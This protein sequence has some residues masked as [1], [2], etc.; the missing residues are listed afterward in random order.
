MFSGSIDSQTY[1]SRA[2]P[3]L[4]RFF[5]FPLVS[6]SL[7][8]PKP[9]L[10]TASS[11]GLTRVLDR[12]FH[13][14][15]LL[16]GIFLTILLISLFTFNIRR[17]MTRHGWN[18]RVYLSELNPVGIHDIMIDAT[19]NRYDWTRGKQL[20]LFPWISNI[21]IR[22][23]QN[24]LFIAWPVLVSVYYSPQSVQRRLCPRS[25]L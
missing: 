17:F 14:L 20:I 12:V 3:F 9:L 10:S 13:Y 21:E 4:A 18:H 16:Y 11:G 22:G 2:L 8:S 5:L 7:F 24:Y 1:T 23:K 6:T 15:C 25:F 19:R